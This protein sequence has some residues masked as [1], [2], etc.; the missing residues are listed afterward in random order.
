MNTTLWLC[1]NINPLI[2]HPD[3]WLQ[4]F[5]EYS[6]VVD[7]WSHVGFLPAYMAESELTDKQWFWYQLP[8]DYPGKEHFFDKSVSQR[9]IKDS[10]IDTI[11]QVS[12]TDRLARIKSLRGKYNPFEKN[13]GEYASAARY[14]NMFHAIIP[15]KSLK[16]WEIAHYYTLDWI[17][18]GLPPAR[19][20]N[21]DTNN[22]IHLA[23]ALQI[24][25][26]EYYVNCVLTNK[27]YSP[28][29]IV[30]VYY[31]ID[32]D[33]IY[34]YDYQ[35]HLRVYID[36]EKKKWFYFTW[37]RAYDLKTLFQHFLRI[38]FFSKFHRYHWAVN[39][40]CY[41]P[42]FTSKH[43]VKDHE[44]IAKEVIFQQKRADITPE[45]DFY[46][47]NEYVTTSFYQNKHMLNDW[48][49]NISKYWPVA[50]NK[51]DQMLGDWS[52]LGKEQFS[53]LFTRIPKDWRNGKWHFHWGI[54][55][56]DDNEVYKRRT[57]VEGDR[58]VNIH[59]GFS[60]WNWY[61]S[62]YI[63]RYRLLNHGLIF[64]KMSTSKR[65]N[66]SFASNLK[67][68]QI[69]KF[70]FFMNWFFKSIDSNKKMSPSEYATKCKKIFT[71]KNFHFG[72]V[73]NPLAL[74][75][76]KAIYEDPSHPVRRIPLSDSIQNNRSILDNIS[77]MYNYIPGSLV[78][79]SKKVSFFDLKYFLTN[80]INKR[81]MWDY[82]CKSSI[83]NNTR[84]AW[85]ADAPVRRDV[86]ARLYIFKKW[87]IWA[88]DDMMNNRYYRRGKVR[89]AWEKRPGN[90]ERI[91]NKRAK[92]LGPFQGFWDDFG[93]DFPAIYLGDKFWD[94][95]TEDSAEKQK[96]SAYRPEYTMSP[97]ED[98]IDANQV[99]DFFR[100]NIWDRKDFD[101]FQEYMR[102]LHY[103]DLPAGLRYEAFWA[104]QFGRP[105]CD[106][107]VWGHIPLVDWYFYN[108]PSS[109]WR[110][111]TTTNEKFFGKNNTIKRK[112]NNNWSN[113][114]HPNNF[115]S[116]SMLNQTVYNNKY[117][118]PKDWYYE[119]LAL[120]R[121][122]NGFQKIGDWFYN[123][124]IINFGKNSF[125][126]L[127][128]IFNNLLKK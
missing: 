107:K 124:R 74:F 80:S 57:G 90:Y 64:K 100:Y 99:I 61:K 41:Y 45:K 89:H 8:T 23:R 98:W 31:L 13:L 71:R 53:L 18:Q 38:K 115:V 9:F 22:Y 47:K 118:I 114:F 110:P 55:M 32:N 65:Y 101:R 113:Y 91:K 97:Y 120:F 62:G 93:W 77:Q 4:L 16:A 42:K 106:P 86:T 6:S 94:W 35:S 95:C 112:N 76:R 56:G 46:P 60:L 37:K 21:L 125:F 79:L 105:V 24:F 70:N 87:C 48:N 25:N 59:K 10:L 104:E 66:S 83:G 2:Y 5:Y 17:F 121:L 67:Q 123:S 33:F 103:Y 108:N 44:I 19:E 49:L 126:W 15:E 119:K 109:S 116:Y 40:F 102:K 20:L 39:Q 54:W 81:K 117:N 12:W 28:H 75:G 84:A 128:T 92:F 30:T 51:Y 111:T 52:I 68:R 50:Q 58:Y 3:W 72:T 36:L 69:I 7:R 27:S 96:F 1:V 85:E 43:W 78:Q 127:L 122:K 26:W 11:E 63:K 29:H 34:L 14:H 73:A 82:E 88:Y